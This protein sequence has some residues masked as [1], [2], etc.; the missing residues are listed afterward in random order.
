LLSIRGLSQNTLSPGYVVKDGDTLRG[1]LKTDRETN[2]MHQVSFQQ[3]GKKDLT[4][5]KPSDLAA[6]G[7]DS[8]A[9]YRTISF[10]NKAASD[11]VAE[12]LFAQILVSGTYAL[13][14]FNEDRDTY[15]VVKKDTATWFLYDDRTSVTGLEIVPGNY[16]GQLMFFSAGCQGLDAN[17]ISY[18]EKSLTAFLLRVN[19]CQ[20]P[21]I[22]SRSYYV[23]PSWEVHYFL[24]AGGMPT[25]NN[26][27]TTLDAAV[28]L[29]NPRFDPKASLNVG[30]H[31]S[32]TANLTPVNG[33]LISGVTTPNIVVEDSTGKPAAHILSIPVTLQY[34]LFTGRVQPAVYIGFSAAYMSV[35]PQPLGSDQK[36]SLATILGASIEAYITPHFLIKADWRYEILVQNFS[37]GVGFKF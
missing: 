13:Y 30:L 6:F 11:R 12:T 29:V 32:A 15:F 10:I 21:G 23:K 19:Q 9:L 7:Y 22:A 27:Q 14:K 35:N 20:S 17:K 3:D 18:S 28:R 5:Y 24:Y 26:G 37:V 1:L 36:F 25:P 34:N 16:R 33:N 31:Y 4:V 2:L 8:G